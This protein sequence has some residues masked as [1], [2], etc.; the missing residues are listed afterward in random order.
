MNINIENIDLHAVEYIIDLI[1]KD[2][3]D[4]EGNSARGGRLFQEVWTLKNLLQQ[5]AYLTRNPE[6][7]EARRKARG[8]V[9]VE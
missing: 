3:K 5:E 8:L 9:G 4:N 1:E 7:L 2:F 6:V